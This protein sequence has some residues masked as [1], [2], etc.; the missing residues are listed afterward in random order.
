VRQHILRSN[1][2]GDDQTL[3]VPSPLNDEAGLIGA[4]YA[5]TGTE[6]GARP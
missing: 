1:S 2:P 4:G 6:Q 3:V 5:F